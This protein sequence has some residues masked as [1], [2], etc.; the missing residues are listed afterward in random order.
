MTLFPDSH[1]SGDKRVRI[2]VNPGSKGCN[3]GTIRAKDSQIRSIS[4]PKSL[5]DPI[6]RVPGSIQQLLQVPWSWL[7]PPGENCRRYRNQEP[8]VTLWVSLAR[9]ETGPLSPEVCWIPTARHGATGVVYGTV[10]GTGRHVPREQ[11]YGG[12]GPIGLLLPG[13][14]PPT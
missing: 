4:G 10:L 13:Y 5:Q 8:E 12:C 11:R 7:Q 14:P 6:Q 9:K 3:P 2:H 1:G